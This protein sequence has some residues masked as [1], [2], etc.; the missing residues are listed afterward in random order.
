MGAEGSGGGYDG[1]SKKI[2]LKAHFLALKLKDSERRIA[3]ETAR[4][5]LELSKHSTDVFDIEENR[6]GQDIALNVIKSLNPNADRFSELG[7]EDQKIIGRSVF[8]GLNMACSDGID[9]GLLTD[10]MSESDVDDY[11][12]EAFK[13][14]GKLVKDVELTQKDVDLIVNVN[15]VNKAGGVFDTRSINERGRVL[16]DLA[17]TTIDSPIAKSY[18]SLERD[19]LISMGVSE[20]PDMVINVV[21]GSTP[22]RTPE[23]KPESGDK[24][25]KPTPTREL[26]TKV[27]D[28]GATITSETEKQI[29]GTEK[30]GGQVDNLA[31]VMKEEIE[32][33]S[34][35]IESHSEVVKALEKTTTA[36]DENTRT[37]NKL[38]ESMD[39]LGVKIDSLTTVISSD[40]LKRM[41]DPLISDGAIDL[42]NFGEE[43][44]AKLLTSLTR[45]VD[46]PGL[47]DPEDPVALIMAKELKLAL[48]RAAILQKLDRDIKEKKGVRN[49]DL[50]DS[51]ERWNRSL[52]Q[53]YGWLDEIETGDRSIDDL[54]TNS[55]KFSYLYH[56]KNGEYDDFLISQ[57]EEIAR[58]KSGV[59]RRT[60][61]KGLAKEMLEEM[62]TEI[63]MRLYLH[64]L[65]MAMSKCS[66]IEDIMR[67]VSTMH[68]GDIDGDLDKIFVSFFL[69]RKEGAK[70]VGLNEIPID[71]AWDLRQ[72]GYF[73]IEELMDDIKGDKNGLVEF[74]RSQ[75]GKI[76]T[77][78]PINEALRFKENKKI[79]ALYKKLY[80]EVPVGGGADIRITHQWNDKAW[81]KMME[82]GTPELK[83]SQQFAMRSD[84]YQ[85]WFGFE[86]VGNEKA[87]LIKEYM[88]WKIMKKNGCD[89][90]KARKAFD[91]AHKF[92]VATKMDSCVN[93]AFAQDDY[94]E[95]IGFQKL[96]LADGPDFKPG[97]RPKSKPIGSIDTIGQVM[98]LT[99]HWLYLLRNDYEVDDAGKVIVETVRDKNGREF[100]RNRPREVT[101]A[102]NPLYAREIDM[103][104][105]K[106]TTAT[107]YHFFGVVGSQVEFV[108]DAFFNK[109]TFKDVMTPGFLN[110][111][112]AKINKTTYDMC[113]ARVA[114]VNFPDDLW[115]RVYSG[116]YYESENED[117]K[118]GEA[119]TKEVRG[120]TEAY[121][122]EQMRKAWVMNVFRK[123]VEPGSGWSRDDMNEFIRALEYHQSILDKDKHGRVS[124]SGFISIAELRDAQ[125]RTNV[126]SILKRKDKEMRD[127][128]PKPNPMWGKFFGG[129]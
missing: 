40:G 100:D 52:G 128:K 9:D 32:S 72:K 48:N 124:G 65:N 46:D 119:E 15:K 5:A 73:R 114:S 31:D 115:D 34:K 7:S 43:E 13:G 93:L 35:V 127:K 49:P 28:L 96:R 14:V 21:E 17:S 120:R 33:Q 2:D 75:L 69:K 4:V 125:K 79:V 89:E 37:M 87:T 122:A 129:R 80:E 70:G 38:K 95:I 30:L 24:E 83:K 60:D 22:K 12:P 112:F 58:K 118:K 56:A 108:K 71:T 27:G 18:L 53:L 102:Y 50:V 107:P 67:V 19:L 44:R 90:E 57:F 41:V 76:D 91:L 59:E 39:I 86:K 84:I 123:A 1:S 68:E 82:L 23:R 47:R 20:Q 111:V 11:A 61:V 99:C 78:K 110:K 6:L 105:Y 8:M 45:E 16:S 74:I 126:E 64:S 94:S 98:S 54:S 10:M 109:Y 63:G 42:E 29:E 92:S 106:Q 104:K 25:K 3:S 113:R 117:K 81:E 55:T 36:L 101:S 116:L 77:S 97:R 85:N 26:A 62:K 88:I 51:R 66:T 103:S 121:V